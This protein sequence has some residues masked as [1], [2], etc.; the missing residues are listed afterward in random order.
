MIYFREAVHTDVNG[1]V[2]CGVDFFEYA[3]FHRHGLTLKKS[4]FKKHMENAIEDE[5][6]VVYLLMDNQYVAGGVAGIISD[7]YF[8]DD[9]KICL[10]LFFWVNQKYRGRNSLKLLFD[11]MSIANDRGAEKFIFMTVPSDIEPMIQKLYRRKNFKR[12][13]TVFIGGMPCKS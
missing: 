9:I 10:E 1:I 6:Q 2:N 4:T 5:N 12:M 3:K 13:E 11:F 7:Y 8:N